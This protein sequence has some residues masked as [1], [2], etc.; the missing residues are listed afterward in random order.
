MKTT[1]FIAKFVTRLFFLLLLL[2]V[3]P[4]LSIDGSK[5]QHLYF[6]T[7]HKWI[8]VFPCILIGGFITLFIGCTIQKYAKPDWNWVLVVNT[9]VLLAYSIMLYIRILQLTK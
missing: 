3:I 8:W 6:V 4:L 2:A 1:R 5:F 7:A 9:V